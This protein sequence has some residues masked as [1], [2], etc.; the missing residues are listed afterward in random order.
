[1]RGQD[2]RSRPRVLARP[3]VAGRLSW[4]HGR[5][6]FLFTL[7]AMFALLVTVALVVGIMGALSRIAASDDMGMRARDAL[8]VLE[9][10]GTLVQGVSNGTSLQIA[11]DGFSFCSTLSVST[12]MGTIVQSATTT[13]CSAA[14]NPTGSFVIVHRVFVAES[15]VYDARMEAWQHG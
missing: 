13:G 7:D 11:L 4:Q 9:K 8:I 14:A 15:T 3:R 6:G 5:R 2:I 1:M 10:D 12:T